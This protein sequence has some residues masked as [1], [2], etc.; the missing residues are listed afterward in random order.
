MLKRLC[1]MAGIV[2]WRKPLHTLQ[3]SC[4]DDW[5]KVAPPNVVMHWATHSSLST[6]MKYYSQV[7]KGDEALGQQSLLPSPDAQG[8][9]VVQAGTR[10]RGPTPARGRP[11][12]RRRRPRWQPRDRRPRDVV[13]E[14][15]RKWGS[16]FNKNCRRR[17]ARTRQ[18]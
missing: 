17:I 5:G 13:S 15:R 6:T 18:S 1:K 9:P 11:R 12:R 2:A 8:T 14:R 10:Y 7:S 16:S 4:I 3:K